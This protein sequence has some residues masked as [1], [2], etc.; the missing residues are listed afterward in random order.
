MLEYE[1]PRPVP[2]N[3]GLWAAQ[4]RDQYYCHLRDAAGASELSY[5][6][7]VGEHFDNK[8]LVAID[9]LV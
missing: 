4:L 5:Q 1:H 9:P 8:R 7:G 3:G 2:W 6:Q